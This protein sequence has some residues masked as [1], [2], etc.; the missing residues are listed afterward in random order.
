MAAESERPQKLLDQVTFCC[1]R[2]H[3]SKR[4]AEAYAYW[5]RRYVLFH[6][7]RHPRDLGE[8]EVRAFLDSL[9][10]SNAAAQV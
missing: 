3:Y 10:C 9:V 1:R 6:G 5:A 7:K 4:T 8:V 2:R